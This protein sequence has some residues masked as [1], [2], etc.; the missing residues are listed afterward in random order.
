MRRGTPR[1]HTHSAQR[2][3]WLAAVPDALAALGPLPCAEDMI[4]HTIR[5]V[6]ECARIPSECLIVSLV[7]IERLIAMSGAWCTMHRPRTPHSP[8]FARCDGTR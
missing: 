7:Y 8:T 5:S 4:F 2:T 6:Y 3:P 1:G